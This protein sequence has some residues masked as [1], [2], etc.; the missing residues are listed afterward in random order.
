MVCT[1]TTLPDGL[2]EDESMEDQEAVAIL[3]KLADAR[4]AAIRD[5]HDSANRLRDAAQVL[6][7]ELAGSSW[8]VSLDDAMEAYSRLVDTLRDGGVSAPSEYARL[9]QDRQRVDGEIADLDSLQEEQDRLEAES[10]ALLREI[11]EARRAMSSARA[12]FLAKVLAGNSFVRIRNC[13]YSDDRR[14]IEISLREALGVT[15]DRGV[16]DERFRDDFERVVST[17]LHA[18]PEDTADR[19]TKIEARLER[20]R[21]VSAGRVMGPASLADTSITTLTGSP[22]ARR[23]CWIER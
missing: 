1:P 17:L 11:L 21:R 6:R 3:V 16:A 8:Q 20:S 9:A 2:F 4:R 5:L 22:S 10:Q 13:R 19:D 15:D 12:D 7:S 18:L 14:A 23:S